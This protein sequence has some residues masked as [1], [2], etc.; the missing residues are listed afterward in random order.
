LIDEQALADALNNHRIAGAGADVLCTEPPAKDN[1]LLGAENCRITPHI[2]WATRAARE[3][4]LKVTIDNV[5]TFLVGKPENV[6]NEVE[7]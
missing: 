4:L 5:A 1:P 2:A 6:V 7:S 3:R